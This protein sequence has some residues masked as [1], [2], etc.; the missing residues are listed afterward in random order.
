MKK[1][2]KTPS[3]KVNYDR[4]YD[5]L[6]KKVV[7]RLHKERDKHLIDFIQEVTQ[8]EE[9]SQQEI[10]KSFIEQAYRAKKSD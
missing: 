6:F 8:L 5:E 3:Y 4:R 1:S 10:L 2:N 7:F 9:K